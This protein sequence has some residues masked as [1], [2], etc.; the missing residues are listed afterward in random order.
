[1]LSSHNSEQLKWMKAL[2]ETGSQC[3]LLWVQN[4]AIWWSVLGEQTRWES[5]YHKP[6]PLALKNNS[7]KGLEEDTALLAFCTRHRGNDNTDNW[8][9]SSHWV[10]AR[11][12]H[13]S[14]LEPTEVITSCLCSSDIIT[15]QYSWT[16]KVEHIQHKL[17]RQQFS[18]H[19]QCRRKEKEAWGD[20]EN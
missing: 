19:L 11:V 17:G 5:S 13:C 18:K 15:Y 8:W 3:C 1:M 4:K 10:Q 12:S 16:Q 7:T 9:V 20:V 6:L 2:Q 14:P